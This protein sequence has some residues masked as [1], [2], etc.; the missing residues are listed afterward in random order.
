MDQFV[1]LKNI[2]YEMFSELESAAAG[3]QIEYIVINFEAIMV[4]ALFC[5]T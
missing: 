4:S 3:L 1:K 2:L 5:T